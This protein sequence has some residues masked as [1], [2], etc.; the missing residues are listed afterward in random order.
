MT[1][2]GQD[3]LLSNE[4]NIAEL[5]EPPTETEMNHEITSNMRNLIV[6]VSLLLLQLGIPL[7]SPDESCQEL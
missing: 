2:N 1:K 7:I 3:P 5:V 4:E 6:V